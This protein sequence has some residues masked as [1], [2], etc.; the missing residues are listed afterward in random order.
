MTTPAGGPEDEVFRRT[1][2]TVST[3]LLWLFGFFVIALMWRYGKA[4]HSDLGDVITVAAY[5][6][7]ACHFVMLGPI[8]QWVDRYM[9]VG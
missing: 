3:M 1:T 6:A 5:A 8:R 7:G 2:L 9:D 4:M